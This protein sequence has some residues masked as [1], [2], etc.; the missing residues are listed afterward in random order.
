MSQNGTLTIGAKTW[1]ITYLNDIISM[2]QGLSGV[3]TLAPSSGVLFDL[4]TPTTIQVTTEQMLFPLDIVFFN[5]YGLAGAPSNNIGMKVTE[6][7]RNVQPGLVQ[8]VVTPSEYFLEINAGEA[9]DINVG[10]NAR[11][12]VT[13]TPVTPSIL[14]TIMPIVELMMMI[15]FMKVATKVMDTDELSVKG[16]KIW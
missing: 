14:D 8:S 13:V 5:F 1:Q 9:A 6:I 11:A 2:A 12:I 3:T 10:D 7:W 15:G 4:G 16:H